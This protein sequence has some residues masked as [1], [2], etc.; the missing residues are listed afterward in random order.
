MTDPQEAAAWVEDEFAGLGRD[1]E[2][3][4]RAKRQSAVLAQQLMCAPFAEDTLEGLRNY[5]ADG[6]DAAAQ[7]WAAVEGMPAE[8]LAD[9]IESLSRAPRPEVGS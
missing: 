5:L 6:A 9:W 8:E 2:V 4:V 1:E 7:V 3:L